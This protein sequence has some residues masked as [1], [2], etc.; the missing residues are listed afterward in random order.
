MYKSSLRHIH[1]PL[2]SSLKMKGIRLLFFVSLPLPQPAP[3]TCAYETRMKDN[4]SRS[5]EMRHVIHDIHIS[6]GQWPRCDVTNGTC[7][8]RDFQDHTK[9]RRL[10]HV[11]VK[12]IIYYRLCNMLD[13]ILH[14]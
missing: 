1:D 14:N 2:L 8:S 12:I 13:D 9:K 11:H 4:V 7:G 3:H 10:R 6:S 5:F